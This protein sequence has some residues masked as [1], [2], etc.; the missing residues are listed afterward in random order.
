MFQFDTCIA[1]ITELLCRESIQLW[2]FHA[3]QVHD[4]VSEQGEKVGPRTSFC[5]VAS[6]LRSL[7]TSRSNASIPS[8]FFFNSSISTSTFITLV[9]A[10][11]IPSSFFFNSSI[12]T[13]TFVALVSAASARAAA[14]SATD[15]CVASAA[16]AASA[17]ACRRHHPHSV[18][19][20]MAGGA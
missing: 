15:V 3:Q 5:A 8:S 10:A 19:L 6:C 7:E 18:P 20:M 2:L 17:R 16:S 1:H 9:S 13:S 4:S 14:A 12:S 11:S